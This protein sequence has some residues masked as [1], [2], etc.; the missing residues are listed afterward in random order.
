MS[1]A[2][3]LSSGDA[4]GFILLFV[5]VIAIVIGV[6]LAQS[7][8]RGQNLRA[9]A[10]R[11]GGTVIP[12]F[13]SGDRVEFPVDGIPAEATYHAGSKNRAAFTRVRFEFRPPGHLRVIPEGFFASLR[14]MFGAQDIEFGEKGFDAAFL[15]QG[16]PEPW[17]REVM[18][19]E[20]RGRIHRLSGLGATFW[21]GAHVSIE[22]GPGGVIIFCQRNLVGDRAQLDSFLDEAVAVFRHLRTPVTEGIQILSAEEH[23]G[24]G[25]CPVCASALDSSLHRCPTCGTPHH[26]DC[27]DY[28][29]GCAI[30]GCAR[31]GGRS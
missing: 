1:M 10:E 15:V 6:G 3:L 13:W 18:D 4:G 11:F 24:R 17:V 21:R 16:S 27:W 14:K 25:E 2:P 5:I 23:A 26:R 8:R 12:S 9:A 30:Y 7:G 22:A 20:T 19:R 29:G 31:R 28:F